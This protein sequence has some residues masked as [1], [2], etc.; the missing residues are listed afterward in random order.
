MDKILVNIFVPII[1]SSYDMFIPV[2]LK[3]YTVLELIKKSVAEMSDGKIYCQRKQCALFSRGRFYYRYNLSVLET[4][5]KNG[6]R[7]MLI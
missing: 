3:V 5:I 2:S 6:S 4:E 7:L 1:N